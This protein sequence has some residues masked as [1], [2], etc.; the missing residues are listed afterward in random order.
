MRA[1]PLRAACVSALQARPGEHKMFRL[2]AVEP[3]LVP[4]RRWSEAKVGA[5][6]MGFDS[7]EQ[8]F[9]T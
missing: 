1:A 8:A 2:R 6:N 9:V 4:E 7:G 3:E 5:G